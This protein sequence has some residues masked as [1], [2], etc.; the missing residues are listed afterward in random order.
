MFLHSVNVRATLMSEHSTA[1]CAYKPQKKKV[2]DILVN[3]IFIYVSLR[4]NQWFTRVWKKCSN[5]IS[6]VLIST[7][8]THDFFFFFF[9]SFLVSATF[10]PP[11]CFRKLEAIVIQK[12]RMVHPH[13][14]VTQRDKRRA[15]LNKELLTDE[16]E[17]GTE[18]LGSR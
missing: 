11:S 17:A 9:A 1:H 6:E 7:N 15:Q 12:F 14:Q 2:P 8:E 5:N 4:K 18:F 16:V 13:G 3:F 10:S